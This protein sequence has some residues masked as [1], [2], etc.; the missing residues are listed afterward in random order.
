MDESRERARAVLVQERAALN[1]LAER[2]L[3]KEVVEADEM[4]EILGR[5]S[6]T[7]ERKKAAT[8]SGD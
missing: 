4:H 1:A 5:H 8:H 3:E 2:L 7:P 6:S